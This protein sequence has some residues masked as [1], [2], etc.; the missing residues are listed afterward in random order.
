MAL[1]DFEK[2][3][4]IVRRAAH[5]LRDGRFRWRVR[6]MPTLLMRAKRP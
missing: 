1:K 5:E 4:I 2:R 6:K 3:E